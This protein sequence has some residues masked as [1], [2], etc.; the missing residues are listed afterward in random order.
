[1]KQHQQFLQ[2]EA[3]QP[4]QVGAVGSRG[5]DCSWTVGLVRRRAQLSCIIE[6][7]RTAAGQGGSFGG[8]GGRRWASYL[9]STSG[10]PNILALI[11]RLCF[12]TATFMASSRSPGTR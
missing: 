10:V 9:L 5:Q 4:G 11:F 2:W 1:M 3:Q 8:H 12:L 7:S 6:H